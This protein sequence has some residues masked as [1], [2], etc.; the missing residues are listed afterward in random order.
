MAATMSGSVNGSGSATTSGRRSGDG[1]DSVQSI[2]CDEIVER[3]QRSARGKAAERQRQPRAREA[4]EF[5]HV[6]FDARPVDQH[7]PQ[8]HPIEIERRQPLLGGELRASV[9]V[10][11]LRLHAFGLDLVL[12]R[13]A[14]GADRRE[15][16]EAP[17]AGALRRLRQTDRG[18]G[19]EQPV[20][21]FR[22]AGHRVRNAGRVD[23]RVDAGQGLRHVLRA[24][25]VA[26]HRARGLERD[27]ARAAQQHPQAI[28]ALRQLAQQVLADEAG[29]AGQRDNRPGSS[30]ECVRHVPCRLRMDRTGRL[31]HASTKWNPVHAALRRSAGCSDPRTAVSM[32][33]R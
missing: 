4:D 27:R 30:T 25:E 15:E 13:A 26:D 23:D 10:D 12:D 11:R 28:A 19:V 24:R 6:A 22:H 7:R 14:L 1:A 31:E 33:P 16:H 29:R 2:A 5:R 18:F 20:V 17:R 9:G 3:E 21:V 32:S 8:R